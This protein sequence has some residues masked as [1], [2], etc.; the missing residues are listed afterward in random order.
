MENIEKLPPPFW[1]ETLISWQYSLGQLIESEKKINDS[2]K[3]DKHLRIDQTKSGAQYYLIEKRGQK[4]GKYIPKEN[5][6]VVKKLAQYRY[7][8]KIFPELQ[9][10]YDIIEKFLHNYQKVNNKNVSIYSFE[11]CYEKL[12][13]ARKNLVVPVTFPDK[14]YAKFWNQSKNKEKVNLTY[15]DEGKIFATK[16]DEKV[17]SKSEVIIA[18]AL[19]NYGIPYFYELPIKIG[20]TVYPDFTCLNV[21]TRKEF[22]WEHF[23]LMDNMEYASKNTNKIILYEKYGYFLGK[24]LI[25]TMETHDM[26]LT[27]QRVE[28]IVKEYLL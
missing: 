11:K 5:I 15:M 1:L 21:R 12:S 10:Q 28:K 14:L 16:N 27:P 18:D 22:I 20:K 9:K 25:I 17:R 8:I 4:I 7:N 6:Q 13:A 24:N 23:G 26:P 19:A 3:T 2:E